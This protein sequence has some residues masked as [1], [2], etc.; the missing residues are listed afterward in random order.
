VFFNDEKYAEYFVVPENGIDE[1]D[2][3]ETFSLY[4][5]DDYDV[6]EKTET[7]EYHIPEGYDGIFIGGSLAGCK[8]DET[9]GHYKERVRKDLNGIA[10]KEIPEEEFSVHEEA[11]Y[12]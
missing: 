5:F 10:K 7:L 3:E 2:D 8:D 11:Y 12:S 6:I 9:M 1:E 4:D